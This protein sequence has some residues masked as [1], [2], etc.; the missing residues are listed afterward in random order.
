[1]HG[2]RKYMSRKHLN[3]SL[4]AGVLISVY[5]TVLLNMKVVYEPTQKADYTHTN[6]YIFTTQ[7]LTDNR[8]PTK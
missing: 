6:L 3:I 5:Y 2:W 8:L 1:M 4:C 7:I